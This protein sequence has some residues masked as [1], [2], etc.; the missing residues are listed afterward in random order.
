MRPNLEGCWG[1]KGVAESL[2]VCF[3]DFQSDVLHTTTF[4]VDQS[5]TFFDMLAD[6]SL[7]RCIKLLVSQ[8]YLVQCTFLHQSPNSAVNHVSGSTGRFGGHRP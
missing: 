2:V 4:L 5:L 1:C 3:A 6:V 8:M 7:M